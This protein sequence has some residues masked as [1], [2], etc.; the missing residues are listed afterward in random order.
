[1]KRDL[2]FP[3]LQNL[4]RVSTRGRT[5]FS[6]TAQPTTEANPFTLSL[7]KGDYF[8]HYRICVKK[9]ACLSV[10]IFQLSI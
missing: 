7:S 4:R 6:T 9:I 10:K 8:R 2:Y 5:I 3:T 1:M